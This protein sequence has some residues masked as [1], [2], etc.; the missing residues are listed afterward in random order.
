MK[1]NKD[2]CIYC[3]YNKDKDRKVEGGIPLI[4]HDKHNDIILNVEPDL[5]ILKLGSRKSNGHFVPIET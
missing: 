2:G 3:N 5:S 1:I 4:I